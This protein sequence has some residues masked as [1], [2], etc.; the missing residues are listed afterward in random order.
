MVLSDNDPL[1]IQVAARNVEDNRH[2]L[3]DVQIVHQLLDWR[4]PESWPTGHGSVLGAD[5]LYEPEFAEWLAVLLP[6]VA[7]ERGTVLLADPVGRPNRD[8]F[9]SAL[10]SHAPHAMTRVTRSQM[11]DQV[12]I[13]TI[14]NLATD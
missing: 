6:Q 2:I 10:R 12:V 14:E 9:L 1:S 13:I 7:A 8:R 4:S 11:T 5:V 3:G